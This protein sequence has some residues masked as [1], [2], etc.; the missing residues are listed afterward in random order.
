MAP[1]GYIA[2][3]ILFLVAM[4]FLVPIL[5]KGMGAAYKTMGY[6][7]KKIEE[8]NNRQWKAIADYLGLQFTAVAKPED[9]KV[10]QGGGVM[11]KG[12]YR[13]KQ[14]EMRFLS[15]TREYASGLTTGFTWKNDRRIMVSSNK[16]DQWRIEPK[17][18]A[19]VGLQTGN[20]DFDKVL[21][22]QGKPLNLTQDQIKK[23]AQYGWMNL[24]MKDGWLTLND[25]YMEHVQATRGSMAMIN[26]VHPIWGTSAK[27]VQVPPERVKALLDLLVEIA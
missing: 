2:L 21:S 16:S 5:N 13:D 17:S 8:E 20:A 24:A 12:P 3:F 26:V 4:K 1:W 6:D 25:D 23:I 9:K 14:V 15:E 11:L 7:P 22:F 19:V 10:W 18:N 27:Q